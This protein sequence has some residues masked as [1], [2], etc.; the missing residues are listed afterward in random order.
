MS[1]PLTVP[2]PSSPPSVWPTRKELD[3]IIEITDLLADHS[4]EFA[5]HLMRLRECPSDVKALNHLKREVVKYEES[6]RDGNGPDELCNACCPDFW[7]ID[8]ELCEPKRSEVAKMIGGLVGSF[9]TSNVKNP[10][11]FIRHMIDDV[12]ALYP[13]FMVLETTCRALR[14]EQKFVPSIS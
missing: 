14:T 7:W 12:L 5:K 9:P 8:K 3:H 6:V 1:K 4:D 2:E 11:V 13:D 10:E